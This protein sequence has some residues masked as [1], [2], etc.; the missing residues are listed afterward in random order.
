MTSVLAVVTPVVAAVLAGILART[1][2]PFLQTLRDN[3]DT[4]FDKAFLVPAVVSVVIALI[5]SPFIFAALPADQL[6]NAAPDLLDL[7][8]LFAAAWGLTDVAR[9]AQKFIGARSSAG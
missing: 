1:I 6:G 3:P 9:E 4:K 5:T 7:A 2:L 8:L